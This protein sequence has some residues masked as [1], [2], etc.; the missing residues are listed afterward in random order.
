MSVKKILIDVR[1]PEEFDAGHYDGAINFE[2]SLITGGSLPEIPKNSKIEVYCMSG[3][4][5]EMAKQILK[6]NGFKDVENIGG[7]E[8]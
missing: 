4:R 5:A 1:T 8:V 3:G 2:L 7:Y 6:Q